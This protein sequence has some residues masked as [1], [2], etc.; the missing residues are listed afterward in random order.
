MRLCR[1]PQEE[2]AETMTLAC[3]LGQYNTLQRALDA[4]PL[5]LVIG[6]LFLNTNDT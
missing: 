2:E 6:Q 5:L 3:N 4:H 1:S